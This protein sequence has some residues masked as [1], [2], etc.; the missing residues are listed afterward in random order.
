[1]N[2]ENIAF[3][4]AGVIVVLLLGMGTLEFYH[5]TQ[6]TV[7]YHV[8]AEGNALNPEDVPDDAQLVNMTEIDSRTYSV[9][10]DSLDGEQTTAEQSGDDEWDAIAEAEYAEIDGKYYAI[11][12]GSS[13]PAFT[14]QMLF[15]WSVSVAIA[16]GTGLIT[17]RAVLEFV[18]CLSS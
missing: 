8:Q 5:Q 16:L 7:A 11:N 10:L 9:L 6:N 12:S 17:K 13:S 3:A 14:G 18:N 1:M 4:T 2:N 15:M